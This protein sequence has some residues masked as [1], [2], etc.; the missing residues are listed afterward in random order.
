MYVLVS[1]DHDSMSAHLTRSDFR[2]CCISTAIDGTNDGMLWNANEEERNI[3]SV[4]NMK[5]LN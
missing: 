1:V 4:R 5:V 3:R 2:K